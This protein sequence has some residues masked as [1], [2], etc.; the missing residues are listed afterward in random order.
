VNEDDCEWV[1]LI[2]HGQTVWNTQ[3]RRQ[4]QLD[5]PLTLDGLRHAQTTANLMTAMNADRV[6]SSPLGRARTTAAVIASSLALP[7]DVI[8][9][10]REVHH[11]RIAGL[12]DT[13]IEQG[14]P[15]VATDRARDKYRYRYPGGE[16]YAD[17]DRRA[18]HALRQI[19]TTGTRRPVIVAHEMIGR[20]L[21]RNLLN[22]DPQTAL[23]FSHPHDVIYRVSIAERQADQIRSASVTSFWP[24]PAGS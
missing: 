5:S 1:Y 14:H 17:A 15:Q 18:E 19:A 23:G 22:L 4:G 3:R 12:T 13:E 21:V 7:V 16:S 6:F 10:L 11:G 20:M 24:L 2:R 8:D 9:D